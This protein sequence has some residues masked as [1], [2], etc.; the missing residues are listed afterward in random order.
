MVAPL[1]IDQASYEIFPSWNSHCPAQTFERIF[2]KPYLKQYIYSQPGR[3]SLKKAE[4]FG[5]KERQKIFLCPQRISKIE[6]YANDYFFFPRHAALNVTLNVNC[7]KTDK[8]TRERKSVEMVVGFLW[9]LQKW[10]SLAE[11]G[12]LKFH[13]SSRWYLK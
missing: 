5:F 1:S 12:S 3:F 8:C 4:K 11:K 2:L 10:L 9:P 6:I 7:F 13:F